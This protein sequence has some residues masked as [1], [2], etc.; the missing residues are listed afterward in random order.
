MFGTACCAGS[1]GNNVVFWSRARKH[2]GTDGTAVN[3][4]NV[5]LT[6]HLKRFKSCEDKFNYVA[7]FVSR[8]DTKCFVDWILRYYLKVL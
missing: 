8:M 7:L 4:D 2:G 3:T 5:M 6:Q 1:S